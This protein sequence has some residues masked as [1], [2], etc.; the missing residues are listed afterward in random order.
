M[1]SFAGL[2]DVFYYVFLVKAPVKLTN[3]TFTEQMCGKM[4]KSQNLELN[5]KQK[6]LLLKRLGG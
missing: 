6:R 3:L 2:F 1:D 4:P 5:T